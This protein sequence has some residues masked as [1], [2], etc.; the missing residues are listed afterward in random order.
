MA[1]I[2][3][4]TNVQLSSEER[5]YLVRSLEGNRSDAFFPRTSLVCQLGA[6]L[7]NHTGVSFVSPNH[8]ADVVE[9]LAFGPG[10]ETLPAFLDNIAVHDWMAAALDLA[11]AKPV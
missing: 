7:A 5:T 11:P 8:T 3:A 1:S 4:A 10:A 9:L 6:L 2:K